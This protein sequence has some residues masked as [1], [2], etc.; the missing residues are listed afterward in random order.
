MLFRMVMRRHQIFRWMSL[1][2]IEIEELGRLKNRLSPPTRK[3]RLRPALDPRPSHWAWRPGGWGVSRFM[4]RFRARNGLP[5]GRHRSKPWA[6]ACFQLK[7]PK[8][9]PRPLAK[10]HLMAQKLG[11]HALEN[12]LKTRQ[13]GRW[14]NHQKSFAQC[15]FMSN[16]TLS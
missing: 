4:P 12:T 2:G 16:S 10:S 14:E 5:R 13:N 6:G 3:S 9:A 15:C 7:S 1:T 8:E 11:R